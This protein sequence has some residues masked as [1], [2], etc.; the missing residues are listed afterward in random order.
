MAEV[1]LGVLLT[2]YYSYKGLNSRSKFNLYHS[3]RTRSYKPIKCKG[4]YNNVLFL[5]LRQKLK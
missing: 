5:E 3:G 2:V 4:M 1:T